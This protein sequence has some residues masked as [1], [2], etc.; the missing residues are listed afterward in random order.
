MNSKWYLGE[1]AE[2]SLIEA[3]YNLAEN[4]ESESKVFVFNCSGYQFVIGYKLKQYFHVDTH[5]ISPE[6]GGQGNGILKT[7]KDGTVV[8]QS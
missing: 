1:M 2:R 7:Y 3:V 4:Q 8:S 5:R 6:F